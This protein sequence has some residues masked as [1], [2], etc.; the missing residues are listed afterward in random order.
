MVLLRRL[1]DAA[2]GL[3]MSVLGRVVSDA[4]PIRDRDFD[5]ARDAAG[6]RGIGRAF[7]DTGAGGSDDI[8]L[9]HFARAE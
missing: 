8:Q 1:C 6:S 5:D 2:G 7:P 4:P 3:G 9:R